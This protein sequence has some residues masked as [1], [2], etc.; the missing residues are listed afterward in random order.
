MDSIVNI[1][2][3]YNRGNVAG[4]TASGIVGKIRDTDNSNPVLNI[5]NSYNSGKMVGNTFSAGIV[6]I[7]HATAKVDLI[8]AYYSD[9]SAAKGVEGCEP[10]HASTVKEDVYMREEAFVNEL[11]NNIGGIESEIEL[12]KWGSSKDEYPIL[13]DN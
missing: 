6:R 7:Q 8:N 10:I 9:A 13:I 11:N 1:I 12:K 5:I 4:V 2:N 3:C